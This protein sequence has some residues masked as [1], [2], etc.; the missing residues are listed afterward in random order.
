MDSEELQAI[1]LATIDVGAYSRPEPDG[2]LSEETRRQ[3]TKVLSLATPRAP[4]VQA[5]LTDEEEVSSSLFAPLPAAVVGVPSPS[6]DD[7]P[8]TGAS[9]PPEEGYTHGKTGK[10]RGKSKGKAK[11][12]TKVKPRGKIKRRL[13]RE[14][15][16][17]KEWAQWLT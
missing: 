4:S 12:R 5:S 3:M 14:L 16:A 2:S 13:R 8:G 7:G 9:T 1:L 17:S 15:R 6:T 10:S 11:T